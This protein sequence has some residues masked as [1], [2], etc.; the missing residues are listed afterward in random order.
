MIVL[1]HARFQGD[2]MTVRA[3]VPTLATAPAAR[4][5]GWDSIEFWVGNARAIA[6]FLSA[7]Y[8]FRITAYAG[9]ET[10]VG[11]GGRC[12]IGHRRDSSGASVATA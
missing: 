7:S 2:I 9:P 12:Q 10:G 4:L 6:G 3:T 1:L 8:G 5:A 11:D